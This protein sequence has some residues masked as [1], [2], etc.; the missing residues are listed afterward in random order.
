MAYSIIMSL[1]KN[2]SVE[3]CD[4]GSVY[5]CTA[6]TESMYLTSQGKSVLSYA[7]LALRQSRVLAIHIH[8]LGARRVGWLKPCFSHFTPWERDPV[9]IVQEAG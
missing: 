3:C 5:P 1:N 8:D 4:R 7:K 6:S 2:G 9:S